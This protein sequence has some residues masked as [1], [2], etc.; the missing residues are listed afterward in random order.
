MWSLRGRLTG[1]GSLVSLN[2]PWLSWL[3]ALTS[4]EATGGSLP[5]RGHAVCGCGTP[6]VPGRV[7]AHWS[8]ELG[9]RRPQAGLV[10][11]HWWVKPGPGAHAG[12]LDYLL[13]LNIQFPPGVFCG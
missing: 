5:G 6:G 4:A 3:Q 1:V 9:P 8:D 7:L 12:P 13:L 10:P 11:S 2:G